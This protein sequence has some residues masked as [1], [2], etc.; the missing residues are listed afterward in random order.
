M[1][2]NTGGC[3][4]CA[5]ERADQ[6]RVVFRDDLW[7]SEVLSGYEVPGWIVLRARRH[8]ERLT[9]L[10]PDELATLGFR[11]RDLVAALA[12]VT[13]APATYLM[14]F[15]ENHHHFHLL[16]AARGED[17]PASRR[18][19]EILKLRGERADQA[20]ALRLVPALRSAYGRIAGTRAAA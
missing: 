12:E 2:D 4:L 5:A 16:L 19:G 17:V 20:A 15:G 7:A 18:S 6:T 9:G 11:A 10:D 8:A 13:G 3:L 14:A 1:T